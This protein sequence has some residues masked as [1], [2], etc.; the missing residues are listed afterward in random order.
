MNRNLVR[1]FLSIFVSIILFACD[2]ETSYDFEGNEGCVY[3][4]E[5][6]GSAQ[7]PITGSIMNIP[8]MSFGDAEFQF[9]ARS[10][11]PVK[12][13]VV[14]E[15]SIDDSLV[16]VFNETHN[17]QYKVLDSQF[18]N[19]ENQKLTI[20]SGATESAEQFHFWI[21]EDNYREID[22]GVYLVAMRINKVIGYLKATSIKE[23]TM[24]YFLL[25]VVHSDSNL[26]PT[27]EPEGEKVLDC[28]KW[29]AKYT[30][31]Y[32]VL[33]WS[34]SG[35][36]EINEVLFDGSSITCIQPNNEYTPGEYLEVDLG[37][38]YSN[39]SSIDLWFGKSSYAYNSIAIYTS[40]DGESWKSQG[41]CDVN[42]WSVCASFYVPIEARYIKIEGDSYQYGGTYLYLADF[43]IYKK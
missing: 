21:P 2:D 3:V 20:E 40:V 9:P 25:S 26:K 32:K 22:A 17:T 35:Y 43:M 1:I 29:N 16:D 6:K 15:F 30:V 41:V 4:R 36:T 27:N 42:S 12:E 18:Y 23:N 8:L 24:V 5:L 38:T 33:D 28:S 13:N 31:P 34:G 19:V 10:T 14:V 11:M 39:I 37:E 7:Y